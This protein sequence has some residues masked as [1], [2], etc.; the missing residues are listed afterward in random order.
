M[1]RIEEI[2]SLYNE[3]YSERY[4]EYYLMPWKDKHYLNIQNIRRILRNIKSNE[5]RWLDLC[6]GQGW[7]FSQFPANIK[8]IGI[9]LSRAQLERASRYNPD[10][11]FIQADVLEIVLKKED[12]N[13]V[14]NF[15]AGYCYLNS[16]VDIKLFIKKAIEWT[17]RSGAIY[18]EVLLPDYVESFNK[19][20]YSS[21]TGFQVI[22]KRPD[23]SKW[24][25]Q[26]SGG[27]HHMTSPPLKLFTEML[28]KRFETVEAKYDGG[29][30][31]HVIGINKY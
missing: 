28:S 10:A 19:S 4:N 25:Y 16:T 12:F 22:P 17:K 1:H 31:V 20:F 30:M 3:N 26:D 6:C 5:K 11:I 29:F 24:S 27:I 13:L 7:H 14:T 15:W 18:L 9:D 21:Q 23:F 8:K 2:K